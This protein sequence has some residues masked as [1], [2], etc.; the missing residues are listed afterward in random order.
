MEVNS[1]NKLFA[2]SDIK[3]KVGDI[4]KSDSQTLVN[5]VNCVGIMGKGIALEFK[6]RFPEMYSDYIARCKSG[7]VRLGSPYLYKSLVEPWILNFP[8]KK[9][10]RSV[11]L[12][13]DIIS[14]LNHLKKNYEKWGI[15]SIAVPPLGCGLGQLDWTI[16]GPT[17]YKRLKT[18]NIPIELYAPH[19]TPLE[20]LEESFLNADEAF[21]P[22]QDSKEQRIEP[23]WIAIIV[24]LDKIYAESYHWPIGR[25]AFQKIV[26][27]ATE[28]GMPTGL[29]FQKG[30]YGPFSSG[31]KKTVARLINNGLVSESRLGKMFQIKPG[32]TY[33]NAKETY[34]DDISRW[35]PIIERVADLFLRM[36]TKDAELAATV[37]FTAR[38]IDK[39]LGSKVSEMDVFTAAKDWK[40][41]RRPPIEDEELAKTIRKLHLLKWLD[42]Q[43]S[44]NLPVPKDPI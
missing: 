14:G 33:Y 24:V 44:T 5:T 18:L 19:G 40:A 12:I 38:N 28:E 23:G 36:T 42:L 15:T 27:F 7:E 30:S 31:L 41:K 13:S 22:R 10:W 35:K 25:I 29:T 8:T 2:M 32:H 11:S 4:F 1:F 34:K 6:K 16:V 37:H 39:T 21:A 26:Y 43:P 9:H 17:L 20:Q 3:I